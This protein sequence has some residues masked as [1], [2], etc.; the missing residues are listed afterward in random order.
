[1]PSRL[2]PVAMLP[3]SFLADFEGDQWTFLKPPLDDLFA[4]YGIDVQELEI[5][6]TLSKQVFKQASRGRLLLVEVDAFHLPDTRGLSYGLEHTKTTIGINEIDFKSERLGYFHNSGYYNLE[7]E[8]F[9]DVLQLTGADTG[10]RLPPYT[11]FAKFDTRSAGPPDM[12][13]ET[14]LS[15]ARHHLRRRPQRNP[16]VAFRA[17][18]ACDVELLIGGSISYYHKYAF[19]NLRQLGAAFQMAAV[20]VRWLEQQEAGLEAAAVAFDAISD[21]AKAL[22]FKM[23]RAV[24]AKKP[25]QYELAMDTLES[26]WQHAFDI[27]SSTLQDPLRGRKSILSRTALGAASGAPTQMRE[28]IPLRTLS[29]YHGTSASE[30]AL[31]HASTSTTDG[32]SI[33]VRRAP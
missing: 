10:E 28:I 32:I 25:I 27:L 11:E 19:A 13:A 1:M 14:S 16:F 33:S 26:N 21:A 17:Q 8:D 6:D 30:S 31:K 23:A 15:I 5:W 20:Y 3:F 12:L 2:D 4:L 29:T 18:F 9:R 24:N 22:L 7:G